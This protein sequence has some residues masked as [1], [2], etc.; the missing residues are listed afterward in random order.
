MQIRMAFID[1]TNFI[2]LCTSTEK[3]FIC[4]PIGRALQNQVLLS[5]GFCLC[6]W[7]V[8]IVFRPNIALHTP[9]MTGGASKQQ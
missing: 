3:F 9:N 5:T 6:L 8:A 7:R 2:C 4:R 1:C